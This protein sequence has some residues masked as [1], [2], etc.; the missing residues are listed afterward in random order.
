MLGE[1]PRQLRWRHHSESPVGLAPEAAAD[2]R[3]L[4]AR[5]FDLTGPRD[6]PKIQRSCDD[7]PDDSPEVVTDCSTPQPM[8][9]MGRDWSIAPAIPCPPRATPRR[10]ATTRATACL[11]YRRATT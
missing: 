3:T 11:D 2:K 5:H 4:S 6:E 7:S 1:C 10:S 8:A 9:T